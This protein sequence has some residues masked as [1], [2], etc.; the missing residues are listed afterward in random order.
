LSDNKDS[1]F[2]A[3]ILASKGAFKPYNSYFGGQKRRD[4]Q[5]ETYELEQKTSKEIPRNNT[6]KK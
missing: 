2:E 6:K 3:I 4:N 1:G 5:C